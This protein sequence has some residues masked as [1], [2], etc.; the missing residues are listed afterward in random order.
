MKKRLR[1]AVIVLALLTAHVVFAASED[2]F[3]GGS[4]DGYAQSSILDA[5]LAIPAGTII[6]IH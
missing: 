3:K 5:T 2:R 1:V 6:T 4:Y